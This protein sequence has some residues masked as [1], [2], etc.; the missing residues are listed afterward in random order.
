MHAVGQPTAYRAESIGPSLPTG[1]DIAKPVSAG[2]R[3]CHI[4]AGIDWDRNHIPRFLVQLRYLI[5]T[6]PVQWV[7]IVRIDH[8]ETAATGHDGYTEGLHVNVHRQTSR[9]VHLP[10]AHGP[11]PAS[12]GALIRSSVDY[13]RTLDVTAE[14]ARTIEGTLGNGNI[15]ADDL[16]GPLAGESLD[17]LIDLIK[18]D[19]AYV[20]LYTV[21]NPAGEIREQLGTESM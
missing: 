2:R 15:T 1:Y 3:D 8:N 10:V 16:V 14:E 18:S 19:D 9:S 6:D 5:A 20:N 17:T 11:L 4:T 13:F 21:A 7:T 12:R